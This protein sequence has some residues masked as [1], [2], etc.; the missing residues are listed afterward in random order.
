MA[1]FKFCKKLLDV[2]VPWCN[3]WRGISVVW[4]I[5]SSRVTVRLNTS[6]L[7]VSGSVSWCSFCSPFAAK[8][9]PTHNKPV[10]TQWCKNT[11]CRDLHCCPARGV[12]QLWPLENRDRRCVWS[13]HQN[14]R[15]TLILCSRR[16]CPG[17]RFHFQ[18][19]P[20]FLCLNCVDWTSIG[21]DYW[22]YLWQLAAVV[23]EVSWSSDDTW[24]NPSMPRYVL[25]CLSW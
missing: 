3:I 2:C 5:Y 15:L 23:W 19:E 17:S 4:S 25:T 20:I 22:T 14:T 10:G 21:L 1:V 24:S 18:G 12:L 13:H 8:Y 6:A 9:Q 11:A 16:P 7:W